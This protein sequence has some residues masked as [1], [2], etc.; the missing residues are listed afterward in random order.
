MTEF[1][2]FLCPECG[3]DKRLNGAGYVVHEPDCSIG[4]EKEKW[5]MDY[6]ER[7]IALDIKTAEAKRERAGEEKERERRLTAPKGHQFILLRS[8]HNNPKDPNDWCWLI[9]CEC[10]FKDLAWSYDD[11]DQARADHRADYAAS[12]PT[13]PPKPPRR[14]VPAPSTPKPA[15]QRIQ[16]QQIK[17]KR[18][19]Y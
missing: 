18:V 17:P 5:R 4:R 8:G 12:A 9:Q 7:M 1:D 14:A 10:G 2:P 3:V 15:R 19:I 11:A 13:A 16:Q 6:W